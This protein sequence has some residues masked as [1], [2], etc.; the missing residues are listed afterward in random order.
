MSGAPPHHFGRSTAAT[1]VG[2]AVS[3]VLVVLSPILLFLLAPAADLFARGTVG[4][5][6]GGMLVAGFTLLAF[7][8]CLALPW[9]FLRRW[10]RR[11]E[12]LLTLRADAII[13]H[14][15]GDRVVPWEA[16]TGASL[17]VMRGVPMLRLALRG[18]SAL[19]RPVDRFASGPDGITIGLGLL[20]GP[21]QAVLAAIEER[22]ET[23][24]DLRPTG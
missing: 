12:P 9:V 8:I 13:I 2:C 15:D 16:V 4:G 7:C 20:K 19:P 14:D 6:A 5:T 24:P 3:L 17:M 11:H 22:L 1:G 18:G 23:A 10:R 21:P